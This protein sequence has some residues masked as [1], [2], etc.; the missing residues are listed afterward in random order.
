MDGVYYGLLVI[1]KEFLPLFFKMLLKAAAA[2]S[3]T[4][5]QMLARNHYSSRYR[6]YCP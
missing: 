2:C 4:V 1:V 6:S 3:T 5:T